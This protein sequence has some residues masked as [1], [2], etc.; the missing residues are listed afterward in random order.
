MP[1]LILLI[2][3]EKCFLIP[4]EALLLGF[5]FY[6]FYEL[7]RV[8]RTIFSGTSDKAIFELRLTKEL[9]V[10]TELLIEV[11]ILHFG[12]GGDGISQNMFIGADLR[13]IIVHVGQL[14]FR[15]CLFVVTLVQRT[16][17]AGV[18]ALSLNLA[19]HKLVI[20][21]GFFLELFLVNQI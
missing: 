16:V 8:K 5:H 11:G 4:S 7:A 19:N 1:S 18:L 21:V 9:V 20:S 13:T 6:L 3:L 12:V 14:G 2:N 15:T 10:L 17:S